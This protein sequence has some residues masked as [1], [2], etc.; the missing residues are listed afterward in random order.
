MSAQKSENYNAEMVDL[1]M[2]KKMR[3]AKQG[4]IMVLAIPA[5]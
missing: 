2:I 3:G 5:S 1:I 4:K